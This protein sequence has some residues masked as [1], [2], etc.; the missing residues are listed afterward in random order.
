MGLGFWR[1]SVWLVVVGLYGAGC[2]SQP[3][4]KIAKPATRAVVESEYHRV[5]QLLGFESPDDLLF[6]SADGGQVHIDKIHARSGRAGLLV[7]KSTRRFSIK[8]ATLL[9]GREFPGSWTLIG[10]HLYSHEAVSCTMGI[11]SSQ[12]MLPP[13][14]LKLMADQWTAGLIDISSFK[15]ALPED[16]CLVVDFASPLAE[17]VYCDD[18]LLIDNSKTMVAASDGADAWTVRRL[19][20]SW[21]VERPMQFR[22]FLPTEQASSDGWQ[23]KESN[24]VRAIFQSTGET[25]RLAIYSDGRSYWDG[26][27]KDLSAIG[28]SAAYEIQH[29]RPASISIPIEQGRIDRNVPGDVNHDG[30]NETTGV[31]QISA[32][33]RRLEITIMPRTD[34]VFQP[35]LEIQHLPAGEIRATVEGALAGDVLRLNDGRVLITVASAIQRATV[36]DVRVR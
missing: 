3:A 25:K 27:F 21:I 5:S 1:L 35:V 4:V 23:L 11:V 19:G 8:L 28:G 12:A 34:L 16:A 7:P 18:V 14:G 9:S 26:I 13:R 29:H 32:T 33:G 10:V 6:V 15:R 24:R 22:V 30:Y 2:A 17:D 36:V 31:Y 20:F